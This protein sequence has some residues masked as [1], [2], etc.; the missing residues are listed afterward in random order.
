[1]IER[2]TYRIDVLVLPNADV[3]NIP[4]GD[5]VVR[6]V[7]DQLESLGFMGV[8]VTDVGKIIQVTLSANSSDEALQ[9]MEEASRTFLANSIIEDFQVSLVEENPNTPQS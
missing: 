7:N 4:G 1:M 8:H 9:K 3:K 5:P 2:D 6:G